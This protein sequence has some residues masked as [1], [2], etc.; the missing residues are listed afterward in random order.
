[1]N[2]NFRPPGRIRSLLSER[3]FWCRREDLNLHALSGTSSYGWR[4]CHSATPTPSNDTR[5]SAIF[6]LH[7]LDVIRRLEAEHLGQQAQLAFE[8]PAN[9]LVLPEPMLLPFEQHIRIRQVLLPA[10][11]DESL[12]QVS[13]D[14]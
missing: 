13:R 4:V 2:L 7:R 11:L 14:D 6:D 3:K 10:S 8:R 12:R 9:V 1:R 5:A